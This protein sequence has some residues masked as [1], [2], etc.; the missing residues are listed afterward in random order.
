MSFFSPSREKTLSLAAA[1]LL[2]AG[3]LFFLVSLHKGATPAPAQST[4]PVKPIETVYFVEIVPPPALSIETETLHEVSS[5]V[6]HPAEQI[7]ETPLAIS[8]PLAKTG[9]LKAAA[10]ATKPV[11]RRSNPVRQDKQVSSQ[12]AQAVLTSPS[13]RA[14]PSLK[15]SA[16][17]AYA[18]VPPYPKKARK[19]KLQGTVLLWVL[20]SPQG[21]V[22]NVGIESSSG[23]PSLDHAAITG[24]RG[25]R[26][27]PARQRGIAVKERVFVPLKFELK[28]VTLLENT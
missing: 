19:R 1:L 12:T 14:Q 16:Q 18:P 11:A 6:P 22:M 9:R 27:I 28:G 4:Q 25:W 17:Y 3:L 21:T 23:H 7:D 15:T 13:S 20:I 5:P 10:P 2:H 26:F 24:I 8:P